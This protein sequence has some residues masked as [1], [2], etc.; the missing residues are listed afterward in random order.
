MNASAGIGPSARFLVALS[1]LPLLTACI[2]GGYGP[3]QGYSDR[4]Y[5]ERR[6]QPSQYQ[7]RDDRW[8]RQ[9][10]DDVRSLPAPPQTWIARPVTPDAQVVTGSSYT[11]QPGDTLRG[12]AEKT[13]AGSEAI[14]R[15]NH[16]DTPFVIHAG[17]RLTIP[18]GRYHRVH[19]GESGIA[20]ARAY[21]VDWGRII[22]ANALEEPY[23][24][25][26][27]QRVLIPDTGPQS[28]AD[29]ASAFKLDIDDIVTGGEPAI[30]ANE[31]PARAVASSARVLSPTTAIAQPSRLSG[32]FQWPVRGN[33]VRRFG[34]GASGER[35]DGIK[36]AVPRGTPV[37]AAADG[38][39]AYVGSDIAAM[40]GLVILKHGDG[41]STVYGHADQLMVQRGQS[42]KRGQTVALSGE[43]GN[44]DRPEVHFEIR[45]GRTPVDPVTKLPAR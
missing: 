8:E 34:P 39:V 26:V 14:A 6:E 19:Q 30:A 1:T 28:R 44:A 5:P 20:I 4:S 11:V 41:Y 29:R 12:I 40:G 45:K 25:R 24:L 32:D 15:V 33:V 35:N 36:I 9:N 42:V 43:S 2:P 18:G 27:G 3:P 17:Q 10:P 37:L 21:G 22:E 38:V 7:D 23:V 13:G 16:I 31:R